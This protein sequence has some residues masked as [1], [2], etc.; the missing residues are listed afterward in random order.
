M[1]RGETSNRLS[2]RFHEIPK[3][4]RKT[5][6]PNITLFDEASDRVNHFY[7]DL[8]MDAF[9]APRQIM[10]FNERAGL[11]EEERETDVGK[12]GLVFMHVSHF[13]DGV[14]EA[15]KKCEGHVKLEV[16]LGELTQELAKMRFGG[17]HTRPISFPRHFT[18]M[19]LSNVP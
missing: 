7:P 2:E 8:H 13:L 15:I 6:L 16:L 1:K 3:R 14:V 4:V 18:R 11:E 5:W 12:D 10:E 9:Q 17:D 19:W